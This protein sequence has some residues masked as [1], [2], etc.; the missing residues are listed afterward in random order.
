VQVTRSRLHVDPQAFAI[1]GQTEAA[2]AVVEQMY[3][4][5]G[6]AFAYATKGGVTAMVLGGDEGFLK[7]SLARISTATQAPASVARS[8]E[9][10]GG[11]N[12]AFIVHYDFGKLAKSFAGLMPIGAP[13]TPSEIPDFDAKLVISGGIDGRTWKGSMATDL[14]ELGAAFRKMKEASAPSVK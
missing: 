7:S 8:L 11:L 1:P 3:G 12:P 9:Q 10:V 2:V 5:D 13:G 4:K 14:A 6:L